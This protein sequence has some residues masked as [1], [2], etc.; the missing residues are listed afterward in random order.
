MNMNS[1][2][3]TI[4]KATAIIALLG[5]G[6]YVALNPNLVYAPT[7]RIILYF[8]ISILPALLFGATAATKFQLKLPGFMFTTAGAFAACLGTL[9]VLSKL[10]EPKEKI[11][12]YKIVDDKNNPVLIDWNGAIN[13][14]PTFGGISVTKF[15]QGNTVVVIFPE[16]V[17]EVEMAIK[18]SPMGQ[19][20]TGTIGYAGS[21]TSKL[22]VG[23]DLK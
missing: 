12:I 19:I 15:V 17:G 4:I 13:I 14:D 20:Y 1:T 7:P 10:S 8:L 2:A 9:F 22:I 11:A 5:L 18:K 23:K 21:R 3:K 6:F 16:Q